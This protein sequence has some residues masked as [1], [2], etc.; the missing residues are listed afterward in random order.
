LLSVVRGFPSN[1]FRTIFSCRG[2]WDGMGEGKKQKST[3]KNAAERER[4]WDLFTSGYLH[5]IFDIVYS[6]RRFRARGR[7]F[8]EENRL[9]SL[10]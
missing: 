8:S 9:R 10:R 2:A 1:P 5:R 7:F 4:S 3:H 6:E